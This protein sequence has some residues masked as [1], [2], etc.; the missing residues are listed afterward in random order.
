MST[1]PD[2]HIVQYST[3][4]LLSAPS[5]PPEDFSATDRSSTTIDFRWMSINCIDRNT[6]ITGYIVRY[7]LVSDSGDITE[8]PVDG[9]ASGVTIYILHE[10]TPFTN[11]SI[12]VAGSS[13]H[14]RGPFSETIYQVTDE[15][16]K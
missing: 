12:E 3:T 4:S 16:Q 9:S 2:V 11:Y 6:E 13:V 1:L 15:A 7:A 8:V 5:G 10:L 14:G